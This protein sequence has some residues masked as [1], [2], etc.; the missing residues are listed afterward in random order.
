MFQCVFLILELNIHLYVIVNILVET[1]EVD[2]NTTPFYHFNKIFKGVFQNVTSL[3]RI[4]CIISKIVKYLKKDTKIGKKYSL[5][6]GGGGG[7]HA[8]F[9][10]G[11]LFHEFINFVSFIPRHRRPD[12]NFFWKRYSKNIE[13]IYVQKFSLK[14]CLL[15]RDFG[16]YQP[17]NDFL[18]STN[19]FNAFS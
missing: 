5:G 2:N 17:F 19:C 15:I 13:L 16:M 3:V 12:N 7:W 9:R 14:H 1:Y 8:D 18:H 11:A 10:S 4:I 6:K